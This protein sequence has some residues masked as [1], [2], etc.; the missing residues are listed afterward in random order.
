VRGLVAII[1]LI[2]VA[3]SAPTAQA[4]GTPPPEFSE[5]RVAGGFAGPTAMAFLPNGDILLTE[6]IGNLR[7]ISGGTV[8]TVTTF[9]TT[10]TASEMGLLGVAID[11]SFTASGN[12]FV[13]LYRSSTDNGNCSDLSTRF[14]RVERI[15]LSGGAYVAGSHTTLLSGIRT[16]GGNHNA[17][18]LR[19]GPDNKLYVSVG[20]TGIGDGGPPGASTNPY[21]QAMNSLNG[22]VLRLELSG[23]PAA[24]NPFTGTPGARPE[25]WAL[26]FRNP[27]RMS[28][29]QFSG[30]L[31]AGD[32]GQETLEEIDVVQPGGNY[33]WPRCEGNLPAGCMVAGDVAPVYVYPRTG[34]GVSGRS[35]TGGSVSGASYG[36]LPR[37]YIFGD[38]IARKLWSVPLNAARDNFAATPVDFVTNADGPVDIVTGP[39]GD[40]YYVAWNAGEV[41]RVTPNYAR[42]QGATPL[43]TPLVPAQQACASPNREHAPPLSHQSC[44]PPAQTSGSLTVGTPDANAAPANSTGSVRLRVCAPTGC[45]GIDVQISASLTDVRC[46]PG[47]STCAGVNADG[48]GN[49]YSGQVQVRINHRITDK[50]NNA[51]S[52]GSTAATG[53][54]TPF[55][56]TVPCATTVDTGIGGNC[57]LTTTANTISPGAVKTG[58]RAIWEVNTMQV[59]DGGP[60]GVV[61]TAPNTLF[62]TQGI[63]V[64]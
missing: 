64:P 7:K 51:P 50:D 61:S 63:F 23:A 26:G 6:K 52:G 4:A 17:G 2:L 29:D 53:V 35:V 47:V 21:A 25:I 1:V 59:F 22:K 32:V 49:D 31:W 60:D 56:V 36:V 18:T 8:T 48:G 13:Y 12:G 58:M 15:T 41:R 14:N 5:V 55:N 40:I 62:A 11:P 24:G 38:F 54:E 33:A 3:L 39:Q 44:F 45:P 43:Y 9:P 16:D 27:Y 30:R 42:P 28:F 46:K 57:A 37:H 20:D 34:T 19:I 10:C